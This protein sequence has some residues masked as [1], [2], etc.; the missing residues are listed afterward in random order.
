MNDHTSSQASIDCRYLRQYIAQGYLL[1]WLDHNIDETNEECQNILKLL[2][3]VDNTINIFTNPDECVDFFTETNG[4]KTFL[5][6]NN[7]L[8]EQIIPLIHDI[9]Q[10]DQIYIFSRTNLSSDHEWIKKWPK[11]KHVHSEITSLCNTLK[12]VIRQ[13][14]Q[15]S[16]ITSVISPNEIKES[17]NLNELE[18][19]FM[20]SQIF[21]DILLKM[22]YSDNSIAE[23]ITFCR[24]KN[25]GS[26]ININRFEKE[27]HDKSPI[28]WYTWPAFIYSTLN[29]SLRKL[30]SDTIIK[31]GFFIRHL[32]DQIQQLYDEKRDSFGKKSFKVY[33]GQ[34][35]SKEH[36]EKV[37]KAKGGLLS[38]NNF[39]STTESK[40]VSS[41]FALSASTAPDTIGVLFIMSIDPSI[42]ST[43]FACIKEYSFS[44]EEKEILFSMHTIFRIGNIKK[45]VSYDQVYEIELQ[46]TA[47][48]DQDLRILTDWLSKDVE[49]EI[50][51]K[52]LCNLLIKIG[53]LEKA[54]EFYN[55][56]IEQTSDVQDLIHYCGQ[57]AFIKFQQD[58]K[59]M[60]VWYHVK[61]N[62]LRRTTSSNHSDF[63]N[64]IITTNMNL[65]E[66][67]KTVMIDDSDC[68]SA[69]EA[70]LKCDVMSMEEFQ[71][72]QVSA[73][74]FRFYEK[75]LAD[76]ERNLRS[77]TIYNSV[78]PVDDDLKQTCPLL[79]F[80]RKMLEIR[81]KYLHP[82]H[83][84]IARSY[85]VIAPLYS[86][87]EDHYQARS[88]YQKSIDI[89][90]KILPSNHPILACLYNNIGL[91][92]ECT[93]E[94]SQA[95]F[96]LKKSL[97]IGEKALPPDHP[98][99]NSTYGNIGAIYQLLNEYSNAIVYYQKRLAIHQ[100]QLP[101]N[102]LKLAD[103][104]ENIGLMYN[105]LN[106][107]AN[108]IVYYE[109]RL[110]IHQQQL[111]SND[112][113]LIDSYENIGT[114]YSKLNDD[115]NAIVFYEKALDFAEKYSPSEYATMFI[116]SFR[117]ARLY[118][119]S[120][121][122]WQSVFFYEKAVGINRYLSSNPL[123]LALCYNNIGAAYTKLGENWEALV[124]LENALKMK[125]SC[126][127][128]DESCLGSIED[129]VNRL[130]ELLN[131][132]EDQSE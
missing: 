107:Y 104:Y 12:M 115:A 67:S 52:R 55:T 14:N 70:V 111:L 57:L 60:W 22:N 71:E 39:L 72:K 125:K 128:E 98:D 94:Y 37:V 13:T 95:L 96:F 36:F 90:E 129:N 64:K 131:E 119:K 26:T 102:D 27:Y 15:D 50:G 97:E 23:F 49:D 132:N 58:D 124:Y 48:D 65:S 2:N 109:K 112:M 73:N 38:F 4:I 11:I 25:F 32:H 53:Q 74:A 69:S 17:K 28:W 99:L 101:L 42:S 75:A 127:S 43:P 84:D 108:G 103:D 110:A 56:L 116:Y 47:D 121:N 106:D 20:Y 113:R 88:F 30:E 63:N 40:R 80:Q 21:K 68:T 118:E 45:H 85:G 5:I 19:T 117:I 16:I 93:S 79:W 18:P 76:F 77:T 123:N 8:G 46:L 130:K 31:M 91:T 35:L 51:W 92:Y 105:K 6:L 83:P 87:R 82:T 34:G 29:D 24:N 54:E 89:Y 120:E 7:I 3:N 44:A 61:I 81:Q 66:D 100:R 122:Y 10:L 1:I 126:S 86:E 41:M 78:D 9:P 114:M 62:E 59:K 33:R